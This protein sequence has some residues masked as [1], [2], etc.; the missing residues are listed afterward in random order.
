MGDHIRRL[1]LEETDKDEEAKRDKR[2]LVGAAFSLLVAVCLLMQL[3][4]G[5]TGPSGAGGEG[6]PAAAQTRGSQPDAGVAAGDQQQQPPARKHVNLATRPITR[7]TNVIVNNGA[8]AYWLLRVDD[9]EIG[10][11]PPHTYVGLKLK[12]GEHEFRVDNAGNPVAVAADVVKDAVTIVNPGGLSEFYVRRPRAS[13]RPGS[14]GRRVGAQPGQ[15]AGHPLRAGGC[16]AS[17]WGTRV[18]A[19]PAGDR[20]EVLQEGD[21]PDVRRRGRRHPHRERPWLQR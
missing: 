5:D 7:S 15:G 2:L 17:A 19:R 16:G 1:D 4:F 8:E 11:I 9:K 14:R 3:D 12:Q 18:P 6:A 10:A 20:F 13:G 21:R